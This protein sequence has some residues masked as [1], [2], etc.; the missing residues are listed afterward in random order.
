M[1]NDISSAKELSALELNNIKLDIK[2]TVL[3]PQ[4]LEN[5]IRNKNSENT[6]SK[7]V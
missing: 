6:D 2:H 7:Q 1:E 5:L 4:Y 3:T